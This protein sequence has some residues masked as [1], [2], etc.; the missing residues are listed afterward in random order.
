MK[1]EKKVEIQYLADCPQH[2]EAV[3]NWL[4]EEWGQFHPESTREDWFNRL[5]K[6]MNYRKIPMAFIAL[7]GDEP[8]GTASLF[9]YDMEDHKNLSPWLAAV[10]VREDMRRQGIGS[11]LVERTMRE[12][13]NIGVE[14]LYLFTPDMKDFY[15]QLGWEV[16]KE[17]Y[18]EKYRKEVVIMSI[19]LQ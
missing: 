18:Y 3:N 4:Y 8:A 15:E 17:T 2:A 12:A 6:R 16:Y 10:Y 9:K 14:T 5:K 11:L 7:S 19:D 1:A 13:Q